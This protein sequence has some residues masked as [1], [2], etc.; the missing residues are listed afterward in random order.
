MPIVSAKLTGGVGNQLFQIAN[1]YR[2][3]KK[4]HMDLQFEK[5]QFDGC[6]QGS[7]PSKYYFSLYQKLNFVHKLSDCFSMN[8]LGYE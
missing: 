8:E 7:H 5:Y 4:F 6:R 2:I 1:A 3:S